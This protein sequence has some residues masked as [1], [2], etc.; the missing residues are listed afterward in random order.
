MKKIKDL[1]IREEKTSKIVNSYKFDIEFMVGDCDGEDHDITL[2]SE[3]EFKDENN[4]KDFFKLIE[5][6]ES[7][8]YIENIEGRGGIWDEKEFLD[9][10]S[11]ATH[12]YEVVTNF[13]N[14]TTNK[15]TIYI[16][17]ESPS[18]AFMSV[19]KFK[20][21]YIDSNGDEHPVTI[22]YEQ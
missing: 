11:G 12:F 18:D 14:A 19:Y 22:N 9:F 8:I 3:E 2:I 16:P 15:Y 20:L 21:T 4:R 17:T 1:T 10:Y 6:V 13:N 5:C 7:L